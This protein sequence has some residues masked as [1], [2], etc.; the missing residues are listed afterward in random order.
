MADWNIKGKTVIITGANSGIGKATS[1]ELAKAG[2]HIVMACR[3]KAK[4]EAA[5]EEIKAVG[6]ARLFLGDLSSLKSVRELAAQLNQELDSVDVLINNA[7]NLFPDRRES[8]DGF[9]LQFATNYLGPFLL[10]H[11]LLDK[12]KASAPAR[13]INV[14]SVVHKQGRIDFNDLQAENN[15]D[16]MKRYG[17]T[18]LGNLMFTQELARRLSDTNITVNALH[19]GLVNTNIGSEHGIFSFVFRYLGWL[20]LSPNSGASTSVFLATSPSVADVSGKYFVKSK[21]ENVSDAA[22]DEAIAKRLWEVSM[23]LC[24]LQS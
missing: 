14:S 9:E 13:I 22:K 3:N 23:E 1:L 2:A 24:G 10:T 20:F 17:M 19:P 18:K 15:Y 7:G 11:L 6:E 4:G 5:L 8:V 21:E 12:L 16:M